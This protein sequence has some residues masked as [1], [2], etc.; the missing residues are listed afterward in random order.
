M[1]LTIN[2]FHQRFPDDV[3]CLETI[4]EKRFSDGSPCPSCWQHATFYRVRGRTSYACG[5]CGRHVYPLKGT[6]FEGTRTPL[7]SWFYAMY[8]MSQTKTGVPAAELQ[9]HL[10]VT[11][12]CAFRIMHRIRGLMEGEVVSGVVEIDEAYMGGSNKNRHNSKRQA[13]SDKPVLLGAVSR[14]GKAVVRHVKG[15][16]TEALLPEIPKMVSPGSHICHDDYTVYRKLHSLG[17]V[18]SSVN[19]SH[20]EYVKGD[21]HT[22]N[23]ENFWSHLK[24]GITGTYRGVSEK[25]L[26]AYASEY[27][28]RYSHRKECLFSS[29]LGRV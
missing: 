25:Y 22:Q 14:D 2:Q 27:A 19:H 18:H 4:K 5:K 3:A 15:N 11:Y 26:G 9:R 17:Y 13:L 8:L 10:G 24:R 6:V 20:G 1:P 23:I 29:L 28:F 7:K 21:T 16:W 12:K